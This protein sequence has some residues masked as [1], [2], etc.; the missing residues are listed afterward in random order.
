MNAEVYTECETCFAIIRRVNR[1]SHEYW[2][3]DSMPVT[4]SDGERIE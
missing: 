2:H 1:K 4:H 3:L